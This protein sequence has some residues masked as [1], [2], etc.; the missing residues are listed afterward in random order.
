MAVSSSGIRGTVPKG[1]K[2]SASD[3]VSGSN[4]SVLEIQVEQL[5]EREF[6]I[7]AHFTNRI[8]HGFGDVM[9]VFS[10]EDVF[11]DLQ[12]FDLAD[13]DEAVADDAAILFGSEYSSLPK[14][15]KRLCQQSP[16]S[17]S[18]KV[19]RLSISSSTKQ[20]SAVPDTLHRLSP[21]ASYALP[22]TSENPVPACP[23]LAEQIKEARDAIKDLH[24]VQAPVIGTATPDR[25]AALVLAWNNIALGLRIPNLAQFENQPLQRASTSKHSSLAELVRIETVKGIPADLVT[26]TLADHYKNSTKPIRIIDLVQIVSQMNA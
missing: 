4:K 5:I 26:R 10:N 9:H 1:I 15:A 16:L 2:G 13:A 22:L 8:A 25:P 6:G 17:G 12:D 18:A 20:G 23:S 11:V 7:P 3:Q 19:R 21:E 14:S 24:V